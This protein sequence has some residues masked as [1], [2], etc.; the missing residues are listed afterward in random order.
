MAAPYDSGEFFLLGVS[1]LDVKDHRMRKAA[2]L[3]QLWLALLP[4]FVP[5][6]VEAS[7]PNI[8]VV[9]VDDMG[10]SDIGPYGS[11]IPTPNLDAL[12]AG[13][14]RFSQ[15]HNTGRCCPTRASLLTGLYSHET[16][17]GWMTADQHTPGYRGRLNDQCVTIGEVLGKAGY[18]TVMTGKWHV[19]FSHGVTP[20]NRGF[21]R[22]LNLPAGGL[23]FSDQTGPKGDTKLFLNGNEVRRDDPQFNPPWYGTDLWTE[24][25]LAF[26]DEATSA[27]QPFFW[28]LAHVAPH[29]PCMAP[30]ETIDRFRGQYLEGWDCLRDRRYARQIELGLIDPAWQLEPRPAEIPAWDSLTRAEQRRYDDMMAIYAAM[31]SEIDRNIG[32][33]VSGLRQRSLLENTLILFLSD[34]GGNAETGIAG[35]YRGKRPGDQHS[36]VFIGRCWAHLN[37]TPFRKYKHYNHEGGTASPLI[38]HW[39]AA[40]SP[41]PGP[42]GW[43]TTPTHVID[44]MATC[45]DLAETSYPQQ[46]SGRQIKPLRGQSL[47][48]L[49]TG[50]GQLPERSLFWEHEGNAAIR[51]GNRKLV[52]QGAKGNWELFDIRTDRTEQHDLAAARPDEVGDLAKQWTDWAHEVNAL[53]KPKKKKA[54]RRIGSR[55]LQTP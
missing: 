48:P 5:S 31:V 54:G 33:L 47:R 32:K 9:M 8:I 13:G 6:V 16:G 4:M 37:N 43:I 41:Q 1:L 46:W 38:A 14:V 50:A 21:I 25:G 17:I 18:F 29:F 22:S 24:Q 35:R 44:I 39:P 49:L 3:T 2:C 19:G 27:N 26:I 11:E 34:N 30:E 15:F 28:Y 7:R 12:A 55:S 42:D 23:H 10:F 53:P 20:A 51:V 40:V 45:V 36:D 52:R